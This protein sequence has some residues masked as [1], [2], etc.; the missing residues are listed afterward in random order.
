MSK[1]RVQPAGLMDETTIRLASHFIDL[2]GYF[3]YSPFCR[4]S[5]WR[6]EGEEEEMEGISE[7][8]EWRKEVLED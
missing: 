2:G 6:K 8:E 4:R 7:V 1:Q 5:G 3:F